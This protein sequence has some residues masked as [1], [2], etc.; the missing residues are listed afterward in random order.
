MN[1]LVVGG[2]GGSWTVR[3]QQ[4]GQAIGARVVGAPS[5]GD[6]TWAD[7]VILVK[8][9]AFDWATRVRRMKKP[10]VWDALDFWEQPDENS[11]GEAGAKA[12]LTQS[13]M[14]IRPVLV[15][16]ATESMAMT[17]GGVYLPHHCWPNL[18]PTPAREHVTTVGYQGKRK[19]LGR[20][21]KPLLAACVDRGW[22]FAL[23]P[24]DLRTC[25]LLVA[26]RDGRWDGWMCRE[27][28]SGVKLVN[29]LAAG[30]PIITQDSAAFREIR[31]FG[32]AIEKPEE[33]SDAFGMFASVKAREQAARN[34]T[35]EQ[36]TIHAIAMN[37][38]MLLQQTFARVRVA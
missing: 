37:Y 10:I 13:V 31:P 35:Y 20:W 22:R 26:F 32:M 18:L 3:G 24:I 25:D 34:R 19:Y 33:L 28:K 17:C 12:L 7:L 14:S 4:L 16:G 8:R 23:N 1:V 36:Y 5:S 11:V 27:W 38:R 6:L 9:A 21:Y 30:R 29:A 15:I 2:G